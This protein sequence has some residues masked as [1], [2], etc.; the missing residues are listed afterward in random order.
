MMIKSKVLIIILIFLLAFS[1]RLIFAPSHNIASDPFEILTAAKTLNETGKYLVPSVGSADLDIH[2]RFAGWPVGFPL[3]LSVIFKFFGYSEIIARVFTIFLSSLVIIFVA[4]I[5]NL[6]FSDKTTYLASFLVAIHPLLLAFNGRIFTNNPASLFL[7]ASITFLLLS[8]VDKSNELNFVEPSLILKNRKRLLYFLLSFLLLGFLLTIRDTYIIFVPVY[9]YILYKSNFFYLLFKF[10]NKGLKTILKLSLLACMLSI[11]GYLPSIYY[12]YLNYGTILTSTHR[13]SGFS[14]SI[15]YLLFGSGSEMG[16]PGGVVMLVAGF[17]YTFPTISLF[18]VDRF[19]KKLIFF[20]VI[21]ILIFL[22]LIFINGSYPVASSDAAP[23]YL[24]PLI[25]F[26]SILIAYSL[27]TFSRKL[28]TSYLIFIF[29][30]I[31]CWHLFLIYPMPIFFKISSKVAYTAQYAPVYNIYSYENY[32]NHS[33]AMVGWVKGNTPLDS[34]IISPSRLYHFYYYA[35][36]DVI[37]ISNVTGDVLKE[38]VE[39]RPV[40]LVEDHEATYNPS[41]V[42]GVKEMIENANLKYSVVGEVGLFSPRLGHTK[43]NIYKITHSPQE[44]MNY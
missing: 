33:N 26:T 25:P 44:R 18:F 13:Q 37:G 20:L 39:T 9:L 43:M 8:V 36:R 5:T 23:R 41:R 4:V 22:P 1:L 38:L 27:M 28:R 11:I 21:T 7:I 31:F 10:N 15:N 30:V 29:F 2:Y 3:M 34:V 12:N 32:P 24:L 40:F 35:K 19:T 14:L 17:L 16:L 42:N 6:F